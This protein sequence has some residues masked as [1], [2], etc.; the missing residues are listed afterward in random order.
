MPS[1]QVIACNR[2][3]EQSLQSSVAGITVQT[4]I[5]TYIAVNL[6]KVSTV[7]W[8]LA[9]LTANL[10]DTLAATVRMLSL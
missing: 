3:N 9:L 4:T 1:I 8:L 10:L 5:I 6:I 2:C 7:T